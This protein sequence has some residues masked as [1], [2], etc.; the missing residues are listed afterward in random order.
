MSSPKDEGGRE[1]GKKERER[2]LTGHIWK[3]RWIVRHYLNK[4]IGKLGGRDTH[5]AECN[6]QSLFLCM[7]VCTQQTHTHIRQAAITHHHPTK[8]KKE[9]ER[10]RE[11]EGERRLAVISTIQTTTQFIVC[12]VT[13]RHSAAR[14]TFGLHLF[15]TLPGFNLNSINAAIFYYYF[16][17]IYDVTCVSVRHHAFIVTV[18]YLW[19]EETRAPPLQQLPFNSF[20]YHYSRS[21]L[22]WHFAR[23]AVGGYMHGHGPPSLTKD[24][25]EK[26]TSD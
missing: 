17:C 2:E 12:Q 8:K 1:K 4:Q 11:R 9:R 25:R 10:E 20:A 21:L 13:S 15:S 26:D 5:S 3:E 16:F 23:V 24:R 19:R 6:I 14:C 22:M 7:W 18:T